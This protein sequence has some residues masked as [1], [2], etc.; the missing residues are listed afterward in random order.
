MRSILRRTANPHLRVGPRAVGSRGKA[1]RGRD[2]APALARHPRH[3]AYALPGL[4]P[5]RSAPQH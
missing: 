1:G 3:A 2:P 4:P 5:P